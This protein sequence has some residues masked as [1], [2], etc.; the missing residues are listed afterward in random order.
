MARSHFLLT[1]LGRRLVLVVLLTAFG[2]YL[3]F[4]LLFQETI[5]TRYAL[6]L[7]VPV[8]YLAVRGASL[9]PRP[10]NVPIVLALVAGSAYVSARPVAATR[11][12]SA[13]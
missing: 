13:A 11:H 10:L 2:P 1:G 3:V 9:I 12:S 6:P 4:D 8:A 5:T 7:V